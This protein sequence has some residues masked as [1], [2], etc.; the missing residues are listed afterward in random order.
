MQRREFYSPLP[1]NKQTF[2]KLHIAKETKS[3]KMCLPFKH[4]HKVLCS[5]YLYCREKPLT[6]SHTQMQCRSYI[7]LT[8]KSINKPTK[9]PSQMLQDSV[10]ILNVKF[11]DNAVRK[12]LEN[13]QVFVKRSISAPHT[14]HQA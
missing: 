1:P 13:I 7:K 5:L 6:V 11:H 8:P 2:L 4:A 9:A 3:F 10:S 12:R 14:H